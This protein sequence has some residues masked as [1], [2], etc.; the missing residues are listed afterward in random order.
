MHE[1]KI[2]HRYVSVPLFGGLY[3]EYLSQGLYGKQHHARSLW[4]VP[5]WVPPY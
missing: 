3:Q 4:D 2:A 1:Q 5:R